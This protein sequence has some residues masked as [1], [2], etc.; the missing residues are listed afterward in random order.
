MQVGGEFSELVQ[1]AF[2]VNT[3]CVCGQNILLTLY[4]LQILMSHQLYVET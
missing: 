1:A 3:F 2:M 4:N